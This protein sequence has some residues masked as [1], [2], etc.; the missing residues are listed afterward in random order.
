MKFLQINLSH[1][2]VAQSLLEQNIIEKNVD[3]TL[4][5]KQYRNNNSGEWVTNNSEKSAIWSCGNPR[6]QISKKKCRNCV[7]RAHV[8]SIAFYSCY[9]PPSLS[10]SQAISALE[11]IAEDPP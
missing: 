11:K 3:M 4:I 8:N 1:C 5:S 10:L 2:E 9:L 7:A 6:R